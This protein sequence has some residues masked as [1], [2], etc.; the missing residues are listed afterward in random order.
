MLL[1]PASARTQAIQPQH[2]RPSTD[3]IEVTAELPGRSIPIATAIQSLRRETRAGRATW[4]QV[5]QWRGKDGSRTADTLW[6][7]ARTLAPVEHRRHNAAMDAVTTFS[8]GRARTRTV[9]KSG[10]P[11]VHDT[12]VAGALYASGQLDALLRAAPLAEGFGATYRLYYGPPAP[13]R[14][15]RVSVARSATITTRAGR[16]VE[17]WVVEALLP[18]GRNVVYIARADRRTLRL[19]NFE[20]PKAMFLFRW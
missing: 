6:F 15:A 14:A 1:A 12:T 13:V 11:V 2:L 10:K 8:P 3:T 20:D 5:Y 19:E 18:E 16:A 17:C 4:R 7:D 9:P